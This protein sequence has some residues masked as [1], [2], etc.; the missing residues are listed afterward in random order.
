[1]VIRNFRDLSMY[2][3][4]DGKHLIEGQFLRSAS[5]YQLKAEDVTFLQQFAPLT[6]V[7]LRTPEERKEKPNVMFDDYRAVSL[8]QTAK[9]GISHEEESDKSLQNHIPDMNT[10]YAELVRAPYSVEQI[11]KVFR[12][13]C[14]PN[15]KGAILWHCT[16]GKDRCGVVSALFLKMMGFDEQTIFE[17][18][19]ASSKSAAPKARKYYW[20]I[21]LF[22]RDIQMA[23]AIQQAFLT[24]REYLASTFDTIRHQYGS[25][26]R[27]FDAIGVTEAVR[28][29]MQA[30]YLQ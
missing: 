1:M 10:L 20:Q 22:K 3:N 29:A 14:D 19:M 24:K 28:K 4:M 18:Y 5:L 21:R 7:D 17:D 8:L 16:E 11:A 15:R 2:T 27:F 6:V 12:I 25:F 13:I 30:R 23:E 26:D 9:A